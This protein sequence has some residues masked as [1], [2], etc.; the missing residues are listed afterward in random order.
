MVGAVFDGFC[1]F[2][3][4]FKAFH[5]EINP[6]FRSEEIQERRCREQETI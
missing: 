3:T 4:A 5:D 2:Q 6:T 1:A